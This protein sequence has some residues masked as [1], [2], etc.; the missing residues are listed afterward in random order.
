M[1]TRLSRSVGNQILFQTL[2]RD[3]NLILILE[4]IG[5]SMGPLQPANTDNGLSGDSFDILYGFLI[6]KYSHALTISIEM[7]K[8]HQELFDVLTRSRNVG[9]TSKAASVAVSGINKAK[10]IHDFLNNRI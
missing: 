9:R 3:T 2:C 10:L 8:F 6:F 7:D 4:L 5:R 1:R